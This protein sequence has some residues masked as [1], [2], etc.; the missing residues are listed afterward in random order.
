MVVP[1]LT[2]SAAERGPRTTEFNAKVNVDP[3]LQAGCVRTRE[4]LDCSQGEGV[5][6]FGCM[7]VSRVED[8][9]GAL[10]PGAAIAECNTMARDVEREGILHLGCMVP[11]V[12]RYLVAS[13]GK[14]ELI[15]SKGAFAARF[16][17]VETPEEALAFALGLTGAHAERE[18][19][20]PANTEVYVDHVDPTYV[21]RRPDG[22]VVHLF[23]FQLCGCGPHDHLA[24]DVLVTRDGE[25]REVKSEP[26][27]ADP[28]M[29]HVCVD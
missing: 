18:V 10:T 4:G 12:R 26:I 5:K 7:P 24:V 17:P 29:R 25:V 9:L 16:A 2:A 15:T 11:V 21:E 20:I 28:K 1:A 22:F 19:V 27:Y 23:A 6:A 13:G 8:L 14:I 3:L